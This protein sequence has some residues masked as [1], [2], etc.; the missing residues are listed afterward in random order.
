MECQI[1]CQTDYQ[2]IQTECHGGD[3]TKQSH[4]LQG[5][6][7]VATLL[8]GQPDKGIATVFLHLCECVPSYMD[9]VM[10]ALFAALDLVSV[11]PVNSGGT[12]STNARTYCSRRCNAFFS[13]IGH[14]G[15]NPLS[16]DSCCPTSSTLLVLYH[17]VFNASDAMRKFSG[18]RR[19][20]DR[21]AASLEAKAVSLHPSSKRSPEPLENL[22]YSIC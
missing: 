13:K 6:R 5:D 20:T 10:L 4:Y 22:K 15:K 9:P 16:G 3:H 1:E 12:G 11:E 21:R 14:A 2:N 18:Y 7:Q 17:R 19:S 8:E